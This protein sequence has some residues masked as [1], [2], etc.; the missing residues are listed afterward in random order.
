MADSTL[1]IPHIL[2]SVA[3]PLSF[4][5]LL[6][7]I[8][9]SRQWHD[10]FIPILWTDTV[11]FRSTPTALWGSWTFD[12]YSRSTHGQ[13]ALLKNA[14]HIRALTCYASH[15]LQILRSSNCVNLIEINCLLDSLDPSELSTG[16]DNLAELIA[17]NPQLTAVSVESINLELEGAIDHLLRFLDFLDEHPAI[18]SV[19]FDPGLS[20]RMPAA[21]HW[22][23]VWDRLISRVTAPSIH[24]VRVQSHTSRSKRALNDR[25]SWIARESPIKVKI[26]DN[27]LRRE[28]RDPVGGR[29]E[30]EYRYPMPLDNNS[31]AVMEHNGHL[32]LDWPQFVSST[33][34]AAALTR[35]PEIQTL[36]I[37]ILHFSLPELLRAVQKMLSGFISLDL[38]NYQAD[39]E[40]V[41][42]LLDN[43]S[44]LTSLSLDLHNATQPDWRIISRHYSVMTSLSLSTVPVIQ[45]YGIVSGCPV[46]QE[47]S[48]SWLEI[49]ESASEATVRWICPLRK[50]HL[51]IVDGVDMDYSDTEDEIAVKIE[52]AKLTAEKV[53]PL[54]MKQLGMQTMLRDLRLSV[55]WEEIRT[56][57]PFWSCHWIRFVGFLNYLICEI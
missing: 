10:L 25:R 3:D 20:I 11:T 35:F 26:A 8:L 15:S 9:V 41:D 29:W 18:T 52:Q 24:S 48:I 37:D 17:L 27:E 6:S 5:D 16:L 23:V 28:R 57:R 38:R 34:Y 40:P 39:Q 54:F 55:H 7:C 14:Q 44:G 2:N 32:M 1:Q 4:S 12:D 45:F 46:L 36:S 49:E 47:L 33:E 19:Y 13:Q 42:N 31:M 53:A 22:K 21:E 56:C 43:L 51:H 30:S 50:L